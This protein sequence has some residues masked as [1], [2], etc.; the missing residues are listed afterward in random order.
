MPR[1]C[2]TAFLDS[3]RNATGGRNFPVPGVPSLRESGKAQQCVQRYTGTSACVDASMRLSLRS[4]MRSFTRACVHSRPAAL[5]RSGSTVGAATVWATQDGRR[6]SG[7]CDAR[8]GA[9]HVRPGRRAGRLAAARPENRGPRRGLWSSDSLGAKTQPGA[10]VARN[11][12]T[13]LSPSL[14]RLSS[15][16]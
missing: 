8:G 15:L 4:C 14:R 16:L 6:A 1:F 12:L 3:G 7:I 9:E 13:S 10:G 11:A 2:S 5:K